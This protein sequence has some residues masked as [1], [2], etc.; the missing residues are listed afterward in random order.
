MTARERWQAL[1]SRL[2]AARTFFEHGNRDRALAEIDAALAID[3]NFLAAV[4]LRDRVASEPVP[5]AIGDSDDLPLYAQRSALSFDPPALSPEPLALT[6]EP[7][8]HSPEPSA[9]TPEPI[10]LSPEPSALT[11]EP[12]ALSPEPLAQTPA[13]I[14]PSPDAQSPLLVPEGYA[15]FEQRARRRRVDRKV[16]AARL[17]IARRNLRSAASALDEVVELDP[18]LPELSELTAAFDTLRRDRAT[19]HRG[20]MI[21][22]AATFGIVLLGASWFR[23]ARVLLSHPFATIAALVDP[24]EPAPIDVTTS[25]ATSN[26]D[27]ALPI[28]TSGR[29]E[30]VPA[31]VVEHQPTLVRST[32]STEP[33]S[34]PTVSPSFAPAGTPIVP[35]PP[36]TP[37]PSPVTTL[38][39]PAAL[40]AASTSTAFAAPADV[41]KPTLPPPS[42]VDSDETQIARA[43]QQYRTAYEGLDAK[44]AQAI[45]PAV[46]EAALARAFE[47]LE[48]QRLTFDACRTQLNGE[49]AVATCQGTARYVPKVGNREPRVEPRTW[50]FILRKAGGDWKIENAR[51]ER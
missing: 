23:D 16:E 24:A 1:Q 26:A 35:P 2:T 45:W 25:D 4:A 44:R 33:P 11:P 36:S 13:A 46:N 18:N 32:P 5:P 48:S 12:I 9:P 30:T 39:P 47:S 40:P 10:A 49:N 15:K 20:P 34:S 37:S 28:A 7:I 3:P 29:D 51:A 14:A 8:A 42:R 17:A 22:A 21:A 19:S 43:L 6:S 50:T 31:P 38:I 27:V 41:P